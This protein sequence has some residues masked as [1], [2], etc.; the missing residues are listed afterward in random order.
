MV[1]AAV[2]SA[3]T[4]VVPVIEEFNATGAPAVNT[5]A[6]PALT[7][8]LVSVRVLVSARVEESEQVETP[9]TSEDVQAPYALVDPVSVA[10]KDGVTPARGLLLASFRVMVMTE[11]AVPSAFTGDVPVM[12][13]FATAAPPGINTTLPSDF[14]T[15][16]VIESNFV[17]A[18][19]E[20][21]VQVEI[22]ETSVAEQGP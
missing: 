14:E 11:V 17:S 3:V 1:E 5:T 15:G 9:E 18:V 20:A 16:A 2:P 8:G 10:E 19:V 12:E 4:G 6:A 22:P 21:T 13:E 7:I